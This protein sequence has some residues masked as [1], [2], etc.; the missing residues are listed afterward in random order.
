MESVEVPLGVR[1]DSRRNRDTGT[2]DHDPVTDK[3]IYIPLLESLK[4]IFRIPDI[5]NPIV[6]PCE[7]NVVY[8]DFW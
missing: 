5:F 2:Y 7:Q 4:F 1:F 3:C 8:K 6:Q